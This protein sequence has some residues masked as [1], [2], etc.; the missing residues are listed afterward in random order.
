MT[1]HT[2]PRPMTA[3]ELVGWLYAL[4]ILTPR[5]QVVFTYENLSKAR[6]FGN[7]RGELRGRDYWYTPEAVSA[8][9]AGGCKTGKAK[10]GGGG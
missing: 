8:W 5:N 3:H 4:G 9:I 2:P 6:Q 1:T 10:K 7:L